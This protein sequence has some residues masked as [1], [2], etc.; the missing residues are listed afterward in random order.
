M[1]D[2]VKNSQSSRHSDTK[3]KFPKGIVSLSSLEFETAGVAFWRILTGLA[4]AVDLRRLLEHGVITKRARLAIA[5][6]KTSNGGDSRTATVTT[7]RS[8]AASGPPGF[9]SEAQAI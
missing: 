2:T 3:M 7:S 4:T 9:Q 8:T 5:C 6:V 1:Q